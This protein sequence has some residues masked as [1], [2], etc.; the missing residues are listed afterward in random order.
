MKLFK[1][2]NAPVG[3]WLKDWLF[4]G[5]VPASNALF[6]LDSYKGR[7]VG[8]L[9][10][11]ET[12]FADVARFWELQNAAIAARAEALLADGW[13]DVELR[14]P[15]CGFH[16]WNH[17]PC[18]KEKGGKVIITVSHQGRAIAFG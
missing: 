16:S 2:G 11:E 15:G 6:P 4:G 3:K 10:G 7:L 8:D 13:A 5:S 14:E 18:P 1:D 12:Y 9:F 17:E